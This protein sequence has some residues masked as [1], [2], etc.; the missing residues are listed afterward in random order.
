M[1]VSLPLFPPLLVL[2]Q[3]AEFRIASFCFKT[4]LKSTPVVFLGPSMSDDILFVFFVVEGRRALSSAI[5]L[6]FS[7]L[8]QG[9]PQLR[10]NL[11]ASLSRLF[12]VDR[13]VIQVTKS[14]I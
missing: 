6:R 3:F 14:F 1:R 12:H 5:L 13:H 2:L 4:F 7:F 8:A 10:L 9:I 11:F